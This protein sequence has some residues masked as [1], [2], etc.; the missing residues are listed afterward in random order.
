MIPTF[1]SQ[2]YPTGLP[3]H[4]AAIVIQFNMAPYHL[5]CSYTCTRHTHVDTH[6]HTHG[7]MHAYTHADTCTHARTHADTGTCLFLDSL[8]S[9]SK[10][11]TY[12]HAEGIKVLITFMLCFKGAKP[13]PCSFFKISFQTVLLAEPWKSI[14]FHETSV[15]ISNQV[16]FWAEVAFLP[17]WAFPS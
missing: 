11:S 13:I 8:F 2:K 9:S 15:E 10:C 16:S 1:P 6:A 5:W 14:K 17:Y 3:P 12:L 7:Y 4:W